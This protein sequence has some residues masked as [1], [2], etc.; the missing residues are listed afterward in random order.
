MQADPT[1]LELYRLAITDAPYVI[2]AYAILWVAFVGYLTIVLR[3]MLR[4]EKE[5]AVLE[6]SISRRSGGA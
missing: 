6:E 2:W 3:R 1:N 5:V 4:L